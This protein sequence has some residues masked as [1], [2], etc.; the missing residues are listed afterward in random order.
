MRIALVHDWLVSIGGGEKALQGIH[1]LF[2]GDIF[3]LFHNPKKLKGTYFDDKKIIPS[4]LQKLPFALKKYQNYLPL[5][6]FAI[7]QFDLS[8][9]DLIIS[10]S[11]CA[12]KGALT[13]ADQFHICYCFTPVRYAWDLYHQYLDQT[14]LKKG[15]KGLIAKLILHYFRMWDKSSCTQVDAFIAISKYV[16]ARIEKIYGRSASVI[17]PPVN[18]NYYALEENKEDYY[19][20]ASRMVPYKRI[21]LIVDAFSQ[22]PNRKL[23]VIGDGPEMK[24]IK[25]IAGKNIEILGHVSDQTMRQYMQKA[26]GFV[27]AALEDFGILP[28]EAQ[29]AGTPVIAF[30]K[31]GSL[32]TVGEGCG[33][34]FQKQ[35]VP[36][37][38]DAIDRFEKMSFDP[39]SIRKH[40][41][42]FSVERFQQEFQNLVLQKY[43]NWNER[44]S[45]S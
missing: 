6:P 42:K 10:S 31:G 38:I 16:A 21:D 7:E 23:V 27:F 13:H 3:T 4:S 17:Y 12:A 1:E 30:G 2:P 37:L 33:V 44:S 25:S 32:E 36:S 43:R 5:F 28:V 40:A 9:F 41:M 19:L 29:S 39:I 24:K 11:H 15:A 8:E 34:F 22:M 14:R 20:S 35:D 45:T 26:K 18:T